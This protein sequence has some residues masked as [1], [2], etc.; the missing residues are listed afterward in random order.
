MKN[1]ADVM[2]KFDALKMLVVGD[3]MLDIY[4]FC[5]TAESKAIDYELEGKRAYK[6]REPIKTL[7][8]AGNAAVNLASLGIKT[9]LVSVVGDDRHIFT[10]QD[11]AK[12]W[13]INHCFLRDRSRPTTVKNRL[14]MDDEYLLRRDEEATHEISHELVL[15]VYAEILSSLDNVNAVLLS[16]YDKGFFTKDLAQ[17]IIKECSERKIPVVVG[18]KPPNLAYFAGADVLCPNDDEAEI[19][20][21]GFKGADDL[22]PFAKNLYKKCNCLNLVVTMGSRGL[23]G[24]D[25]K[26]FFHIPAVKVKAAGPVGCGDTA[27]GVIA[28]ALASGLEL[29]DACRL[30]NIAGAL[31]VKKKATAMISR[32]ELIEFADKSN[33][34]Y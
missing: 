12:K 9:K 20:L 28:A 32:T 6:A 15:T 1:A 4:D 5:F 17:R 14:Y 25:G 30:A 13:W 3:V 24:F 21:P 23:C 19:M 27:R 8:A 31:I 33:F 34:T 16:D 22:Q 10:L 18:F 2:A 11:L 26:I 29:Y 7:G